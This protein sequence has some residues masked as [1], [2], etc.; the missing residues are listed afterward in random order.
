MKI[1]DSNHTWGA[2]VFEWKYKLHEDLPK[3][4]LR[5][6]TDPAIDHALPDAGALEGPAGGDGG[7]PL[8]QR[9]GTPAAGRAPTPAVDTAS[10]DG[11][12]KQWSCSRCTFLNPYMTNTCDM[13][14]MVRP[15]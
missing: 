1:D 3:P 5:A 15:A 8:E 11:T 10:T 12:I 13:C 7:A 14:N 2:Y 9:Q 6:H 4:H